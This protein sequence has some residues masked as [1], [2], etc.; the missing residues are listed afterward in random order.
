MQL[1]G[2]HFEGLVM[3]NKASAD[4]DG[5]VPM[6]TPIKAA[7]KLLTSYKKTKIVKF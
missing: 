2:F 4:A 7:K 3:V 6:T 1:L 5:P